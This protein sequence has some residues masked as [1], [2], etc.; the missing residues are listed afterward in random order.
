VEYSTVTLFIAEQI[1]ERYMVNAAVVTD[2]AQRRK[3]LFAGLF[4]N[5]LTYYAISA[6]GSLRRDGCRIGSCIRDPLGSHSL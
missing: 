6:L 2:C 4:L 5:A 1:H 3:F